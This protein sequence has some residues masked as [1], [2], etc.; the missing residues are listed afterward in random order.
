VL[1]CRVV[2]TKRVDAYWRAGGGGEQVVAN[3]SLLLNLTPRRAAR[4]AAPRAMLGLPCVT[5]T[6]YRDTSH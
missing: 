4:T 3:V 2:D 1:I 6:P 5:F